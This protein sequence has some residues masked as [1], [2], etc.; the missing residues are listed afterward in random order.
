MIDLVEMLL[1]GW[2]IFACIICFVGHVL[3]WLDY[4]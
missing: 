3:W 4:L 1:T 2:F